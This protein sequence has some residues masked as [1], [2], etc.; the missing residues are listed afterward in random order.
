VEWFGSNY[1]LGMEQVFCH[2]EHA[3]RMLKHLSKEAG[4]DCNR[5]R[6]LNRDLVQSIAIILGESLRTRVRSHFTP[7]P[8]DAPSS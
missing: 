7:V 4:G 5:V 6:D 2:L 1:T 8:A 3:E